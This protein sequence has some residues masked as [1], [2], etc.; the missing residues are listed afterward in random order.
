[1]SYHTSAEFFLWVS[2]TVM[3]LFSRYSNARDVI[4]RITLYV[5]WLGADRCS[6]AAW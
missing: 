6:W 5:I 3:F 4:S 2:I 1:M